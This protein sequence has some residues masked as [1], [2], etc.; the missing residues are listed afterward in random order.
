MKQAFRTFW[1]VF[2][3]LLGSAGAFISLWSDE[4]SEY[5]VLAMDDFTSVKMLIVSIAL[6]FLVANLARRPSNV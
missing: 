5:G 6:L 3:F 2:L 4:I 1:L